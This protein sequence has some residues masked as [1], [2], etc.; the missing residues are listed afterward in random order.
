MRKRPRDN[1]N[2]KSFVPSLSVYQE[3]LDPDGK[4]HTM[5]GDMIR[6]VLTELPDSLHNLVHVKNSGRLAMRSIDQ[7]SVIESF[8]RLQ[9]PPT[10]EQVKSIATSIHTG[11]EELLKGTVAPMPFAVGSAA[12]RGEKKNDVV[13]MPL[14]WD[15]YKSN[16]QQRDGENGFTPIGSMIAIRQ[17]AVGAIALAM[18]DENFD[19]Q[20]L[21]EDPY[22]TRAHSCSGPLKGR[23][24]ADILDITERTSLDELYL[25]NVIVAYRTG[26]RQSDA[27]KLVVDLPYTDQNYLHA[28]EQSYQAA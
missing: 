18:N 22:I 28:V 12:I 20:T 23:N 16:Y 3:V 7:G 11:L 26:R 25:G 24:A 19:A 1:L 6:A 2:N 10:A 17:L 21:V 8:K 5:Q 4:V 27:G 9:T 15:G 13:V 14:G